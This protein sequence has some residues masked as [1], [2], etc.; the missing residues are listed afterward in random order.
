[1]KSGPAVLTVAIVSTFALILSLIA[2]TRH[3]PVSPVHFG[4]A[5]ISNAITIVD[6][7]TGQAA[8]VSDA[9]GGLNGLKVS[10]LTAATGATAPGTPA[11]NPSWYA[12]TDI[13]W[14]PA[15]NAPGDTASD[16]NNCTTATTACLTIAE[17]YR[18]YGSHYATLTAGQKTTLHILTTQS[19]AQAASDPIGVIGFTAPGNGAFVMVCSLQ[20]QGPTFL[21]GTVTAISRANP[22]SDLQV[23]LGA[24]VD[25]GAA[26]VAGNILYD[27]TVANGSYAFI[28]SMSVNTATLTSPHTA[29][30]LTTPGISPT[31]TQNG[32]SW[33]INDTLQVY[34]QPVIYLEAYEVTAGTAS[35]VSTLGFSWVQ[36]CEFGE[37]Y[38]FTGTSVTRIAPSGRSI[39]SLVRGDTYVITESPAP[40]SISTSYPRFA[41]PWF[42]GGIAAHGATFYGGAVQSI[43]AGGDK[44]IF[45]RVV[46]QDDIIMHGTSYIASYSQVLNAHIVSGGILE[47]LAGAYTSIK[48]QTAPEIWGAG[49]MQADQGSAWVNITGTTWQTAVTVATMTLTT[50]ATATGAAYQPGGTFTTGLT[51]TPYAIDDA[52]N[53]QDPKSGARY[54][55]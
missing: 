37:L 32:S 12:A 40:I 47:S 23:A 27:S 54:S 8:S 43:N 4:A 1:M 14:D 39:F 2:I 44:S 10:G 11:Y 52:G 48:V 51:I 5:A 15:G 17:I 31:F 18:R 29:T 36:G 20:A 42:N 53:V 28:D 34:T 33:A 7:V 9:G 38:N 24:G 21:A 35:N 41:S 3:L 13:Y 49:G 6:P 16:S 26:P 55:N 22:G 45:E 30:S 46:L 25:A 50:N 19:S